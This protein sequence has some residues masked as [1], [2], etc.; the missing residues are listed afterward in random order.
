MAQNQRI[1]IKF[2]GELFRSDSEPVEMNKVIQ[3]AGQLAKLR[4]DYQLGIVFG[5]GNI[6]RGR[7]IQALNLNMAIAHYTGMAATIVNALALKNAFEQLALPSKIISSLSF[8]DIIPA[9]ERLNIIQYLEKG[10][11]LIFAAGTGNPFVTT[12]TC[13]VIRALEMQAGLLVKATSVEGVYESDPKNNPAVRQFKNISYKNYLELENPLVFDKTA[14][15]L[16]A[17]HNLS[18]YVFKLDKKNLKKGL[19]QKAGGTL[20]SQS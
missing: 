11:T 17:E 14:V 16:A 4:K 6:F 7:N 2:S 15:S 12:D 1:L 13:A 3:L 19:K 9:I 10:E 5:G 20:I 8:G 18:I